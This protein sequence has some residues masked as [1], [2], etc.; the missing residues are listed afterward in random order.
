MGI[1]KEEERR[2]SLTRSTPSTST[3]CRSSLQRQQQASHPSSNPS[4]NS[5]REN[6]LPSTHTYIGDQ[7]WPLVLNDL[8]WF[9][10][11]GK[12]KKMYFDEVRLVLSCG[13]GLTPSSVST[14]WLAIRNFT[15]R[16]TQLPQRR[17][18]RPQRTSKYLSIYR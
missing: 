5:L 2:T 17:C 9:I 15:Q 7:A 14:E 18:E 10:T 11:N 6:F 16:S 1:R 3:C 12:G 13:H 8:F 4:D